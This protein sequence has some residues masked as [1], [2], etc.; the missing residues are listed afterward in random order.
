VDDALAVGG[1]LKDRAALDQLPAQRIGI[2]DVAVMR[3]CRATH[4]ELAEERLH[5]ADRG[6]PLGARGGV[7]HVPDRQRA[8]QGV[9]HVLACEIVADVS[10]AAGGIEPEFRMMGDDSAGLLSAML[11]CMQA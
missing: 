10:E 3:D 9:H 4:R 11:E 6:V 5:V 8:G 7:A 1:G 2:G